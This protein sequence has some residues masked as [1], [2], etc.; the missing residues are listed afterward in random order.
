ME[1]MNFNNFGEFVNFCKTAQTESWSNDDITSFNKKVNSLIEKDAFFKENYDKLKRNAT[2][3]KIREKLSK[4]RKI[5]S[6]SN[7]RDEYRKT[8]LNPKLFSY[9]SKEH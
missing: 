3:D 5:I 7:K 9:S 8:R 4:K 2:K 6:L 1:N